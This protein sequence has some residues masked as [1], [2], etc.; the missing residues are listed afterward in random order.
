MIWSAVAIKQYN[1]NLIRKAKNNTSYYPNKASAES[2]SQL[3]MYRKQIDIQENKQPPEANLNKEVPSIQD[4]L[5]AN[6]GKG[7]NDYYVKYK[8]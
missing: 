2:Y 5:R 4:W 3:D 7:I 6:P 8:K 1:R